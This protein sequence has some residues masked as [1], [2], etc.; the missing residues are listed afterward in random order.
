MKSNTF[1]I[2]E[3]GVNHNG[4][5]TLA[6]KLIDAAVAAGVD[7]V[8]FQTWQTELLVTEDAEM[9]DYQKENTQVVESQFQMLKRLELSYTD[10]TALKQYCDESGIM[11]MSTPDEEQSATFLNDLQDIFKIGSGE[12]TNTPFL[13][14]VAA[15]AKPVIISTGMGYLAEVEH[16]LSVLTEAGLA[17]DDITVLHATTDYPTAPE[18]VNLLAM[19]TIRQAFPGVKVGYSDH[20]LGIE[21]PVAS[22]ALGAV[23]VE[24][25]FTLDKTMAG[26]DHKASLEPAE[27]KA[28]VTAIRNTESALGHGWKVPTAAEVKNRAIVRKSLVAGCA[29]ANGTIITADMLEIKR[30]GT[31]ISPTRWDEI[32]GT[33]STQDYSAGELI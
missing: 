31:G 5:F 12:L 11:F 25:H 27:L 21:V 16:A 26:P 20:T 22:V 13:R 10:F 2:A 23:V 3:A 24:K 14:H 17:L 18:D 1:I 6:K 30:P 4:D 15:F 29:I 7:A 19:Q 9:A 8:K 28:M 33:R 32:V